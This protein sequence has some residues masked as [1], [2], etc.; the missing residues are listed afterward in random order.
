M[1]GVAERGPRCYCTREGLGVGTYWEEETLI[2][3]S[4]ALQLSAQIGVY[5]LVLDEELSTP[6][7]CRYMAKGHRVA[8]IHHYGTTW[9]PLQP[10]T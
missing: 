6:A 5:W 10:S 7:F 1:A 3:L 2:R 9:R 8:G 4:Y